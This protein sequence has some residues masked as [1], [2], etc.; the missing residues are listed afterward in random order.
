MGRLKTLDL[1][2]TPIRSIPPPAYLRRSIPADKIGELDGAVPLVPLASLIWNQCD[3]ASWSS[4][5][6]LRQWTGTTLTSMRYTF[7]QP[8]QNAQISDTPISRPIGSDQSLNRALLIASLPSLRT[9]NGT[10]ITSTERREAEMSYVRYVQQYCSTQG[11]MQ[12]SDDS[13][14]G[15]ESGRARRAERGREVWGMYEALAAKHGVAERTAGADGTAGSSI[16]MR[17]G[18][19]GHEMAGSAQR[20]GALKSRLI[21]ECP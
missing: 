9:L 17:G 13:A 3:L 4:I 20:A 16:V 19:A 14:H 10:T 15:E 18:G 11:G 5:D 1:S 2:G 21:S 6:H 8:G 12:L 7:R